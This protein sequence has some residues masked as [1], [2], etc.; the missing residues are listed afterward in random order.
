MSEYYFSPWIGPVSDRWYE[1]ATEVARRHDARVV[2]RQVRGRGAASTRW[3][4]APF[5]DP[6]GG[7]IRGWFACHERGVSSDSETACAVL[8]DLTAA[9]LWDGGP[10]EVDV[11]RATS[12]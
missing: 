6:E 1:A 2:L 8:E 4:D 12:A 3:H 7:M 11:D 5:P 10:V 9:G